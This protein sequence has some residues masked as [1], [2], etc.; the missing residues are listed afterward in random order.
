MD[1]ISANPK[2]SGTRYNKYL[3]KALKQFTSLKEI[4][5]GNICNAH[6]YDILVRNDRATGYI[7]RAT[8]EA[9]Y[10]TLFVSR[11]D[12]VVHGYGER[13][14]IKCRSVYPI[15]FKERIV[16]LD[17][18]LIARVDFLIGNILGNFIHQTDENYATYLRDMAYYSE[19]KPISKAIF[20]KAV[21]EVITQFYHNK[22]GSVVSEEFKDLVE[23]NIKRPCRYYVEKLGPGL[24]QVANYDNLM[25]S[26]ESFYP[27][28]STDVTEFVK[29]IYSYRLC[30]RVIKAKG[31]ISALFK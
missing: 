13:H 6:S 11:V 16:S 20:E 15:E 10:R 2:K 5:D 19:Y 7:A 26:R 21:L 30:S 25:F 29:A 4:D 28:L 14:A 12:S 27:D 31:D 8:K 18:D 3:L 17:K 1:S 24:I 23:L 22:G 9:Y